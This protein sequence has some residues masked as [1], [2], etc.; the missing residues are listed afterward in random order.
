VEAET[1]VYTQSELDFTVQNLIDKACKQWN[2]SP[3]EAKLKLQ[4]NLWDIDID[5]DISIAKEPKPKGEADSKVIHFP[6]FV[7]KTASKTKGDS[8]AKEPKSKG[9]VDVDVDG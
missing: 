1:Q 5:I 3:S 2:C 9:D 4:T 6:K 7:G 8:K